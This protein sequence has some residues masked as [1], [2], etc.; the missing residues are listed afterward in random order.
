[1][2]DPLCL[3]CFVRA[4]RVA[5]TQLPAAVDAPPLVL[6]REGAVAALLARV[7]REDFCGTDATQRLADPAWLATQ[8]IR[9][10]AVLNWAM[11]HSPVFPARLGTLFSSIERVQVLMREHAAVID[12][13]LDRVEDKTEWAVKGWLNRSIAEQ[14]Q[15]LTLATCEPDEALS[16]G[17]RYLSKRI[18]QAQAARQLDAWLVQS[19]QAIL[20]RLT[21]QAQAF[22][23]RPATSAGSPATSNEL[24]SNWAF[25]LNERQTPAFSDLVQSINREFAGAGFQLEVS[26]PWPPYSFCEPLMEQSA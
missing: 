24:V 23:S 9:H 2:N 18:H 26:G 11:R 14:R 17:T 12:R 16:P 21:N 3:F 13:V 25:L 19:A 22:R 7:P 6:L 1:M 8:V 5:G 4:E 20:A 10:S 15:A